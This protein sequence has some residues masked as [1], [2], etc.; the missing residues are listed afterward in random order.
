ME[1]ILKSSYPKLGKR[2]D[3]VTVK[4]GYGRNYLI[5]QGIA[6][7]A[8]QANKKQALEDAKQAAAKAL[9]LKADAQ[10]LVASID[11][12]KVIVK[13][14]VGEK[15]YI[16]GSVT[17][18]QIAKALKAVDIVVHYNQIHLDVEAPIKTVGNYQATLVLHE[19]ISYKLA[20]QVVSA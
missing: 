13:M 9:K 5:P 18:L 6:V 2:G 20:F 19:E 4:A 8:S 10:A 7:T 16:F 3:M 15:G 12:V 11:R 17:P 14:K 1:V